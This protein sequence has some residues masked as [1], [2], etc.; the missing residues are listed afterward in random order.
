MD[1]N[2]KFLIQRMDAMELRIMAKIDPLAAFQN[3]LMALAGL[4]GIV[5][6]GVGS[7]AV[8]LIVKHF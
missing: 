1:A 5:A 6:G 2:T 3:R 4:A 7:L 8:Q